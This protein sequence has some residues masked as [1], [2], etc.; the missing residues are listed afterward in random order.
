MRHLAAYLLLVAGGN[1]KPTKDDV[2]KLLSSVG[3][4]ADSE[5]LATLV[6]ELEGKNVNELIALGKDK[7]CASGGA[8]GGAAAAP[9][10]AA[11]AGA[12]NLYLLYSINNFL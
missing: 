2:S 5:R 8:P 11:A 6:G 7:L 4:E 12:G 9:A 1:E 10:P 3:I